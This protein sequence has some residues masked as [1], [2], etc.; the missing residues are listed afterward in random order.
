LSKIAT[1][2]LPLKGLGDALAEAF[3]VTQSALRGG[4]VG[5]VV[6]SQHLAFGIGQVFLD[7]VSR[8]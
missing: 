3:E 8:S 7:L 5:E 2:E 4:Q 6:G 1:R